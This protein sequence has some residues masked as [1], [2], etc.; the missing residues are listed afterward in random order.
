L[1][2]QNKNCVYKINK[3]IL[4][5]LNAQNKIKITKNYSMKYILLLTFFTFCKINGQ[6]ING[7]VV[8]FSKKA[9]VS[10]AKVEVVGGSRVLTD[11]TGNFR[12]NVPLLPINI[13]ISAEGFK[14]DT[15]EVNALVQEF[16]LTELVSE[17]SQVVVSA[18]R[19]EQNI[20]DISISME[21]LK[22]ELLQN[23]GYTDL[24][25][26]VDQTP[27]VYTMDG[28]VSIRGGSGFAYGAGSRVLLLVN[29]LPQM[30]AD[31]GD[32]KWTSIGMESIERMEIIKGA[33]SV[34]YG[35]GALNGI[36]SITE[37]EPTRKGE[38]HVKM[39]L[40]FYDK[41]KRAS[42]N[43]SDKTLTYHTIDGYYGKMYK[44]I[45]FTLSGMALIGDGIRAGEDESRGRVSGSFVYKPLKIKNL[46][47]GVFF[48][49]QKQVAG[50][51]ILWESDTLGFTPKGGADTSNLASTVT[52]TKGLRVNI[53]PYLKYTDKF[54]NKHSLRGRWYR[55]E[56]NNL[57]NA[58]QGAFAENYFGEYQFHRS[59]NKSWYVTSGASY[60]KGVV[61]SILYGDHDSKNGAFYGQVEK[62]YKKFDITAGVRFEYF[63]QDNLVVDSRFKYGKKMLNV[64]PIARIGAHYELHKY[65]HLR[66]SFGQGVR[67]PSVAERFVQSAVGSLN[68]FPNQDL[69]AERG[70]AAEIGIKQGV[71]IGKWKA[72]VDLAGFINQYENMMEFA[73]GIYNPKNIPINYFN[74]NSPGYINKWIGFRAQNAESARIIGGEISVTGEGNIGNFRI[75]TLAG[76]TYM[77]PI[78]LSTDVAYKKTFSDSTNMLKYR[79][80]HLIKGDL[81]V[82]Y[83]AFTIGG[84]VRYNSY[85]ENIDQI[86][87]D[88]F[89][90]PRILKG[91]AAYRKERKGEGALVYDFRIA[92]DIQD[93]LKIS[94]LINNAF[95]REYM[96][97]PGDIQAPRNFAI[98]LNYKI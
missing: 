14:K 65:T 41:S 64:Y 79:F 88:P 38:G 9:P 6:E 92:Y 85:I 13:I 67:Y 17:I 25:Q 40:G 98:Q 48:S 16:I 43:W 94:F 62:K 8:D 12:I 10:F 51:F 54:G 53:D 15:F 87:L 69:K 42:L 37:K 18:S 46:K 59:W 72:Y 73:F 22:P 2:V 52:Y 47:T 45:G 1:C 20:E 19:R 36:I 76:Y 56:N 61:K 74:P 31:I 70:W 83:K 44:R 77:D 93:F 34:L 50:S 30:S 96:T 39:Q 68:V 21:V 97:R 63:Q 90:G 89:V 58:G 35:A 81:Q 33:S 23:K 27:G 32:P 29:D 28:Q 84:S 60:N 82:S 7:K 11:D 91:Y 4:A 75:V 57:N 49:F 26:A 3:V 24:E 5:L 66:A 55:T 71:K 95:N 80:R 78:S 86:F